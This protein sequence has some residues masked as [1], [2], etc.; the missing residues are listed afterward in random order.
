[1]CLCNIFP[2]EAGTDP[3]QMFETKNQTGRQISAVCL[4]GVADISENRRKHFTCSSY[5]RHVKQR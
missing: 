1:M 4:Q 2:A 3:V 5:V